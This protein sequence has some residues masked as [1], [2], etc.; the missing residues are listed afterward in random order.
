M[1]SYQILC[2]CFFLWSFNIW[3]VSWVIPSGSEEI[4][5][6]RAGLDL[7]ILKMSPLVSAFGEFFFVSFSINNFICESQPFLLKCEGSFTQPVWAFCICIKAA[8]WFYRWHTTNW[9]GDWNT[10][11]LPH[12]TCS[13]PISTS[14][15]TW[16]VQKGC[17]RLPIVSLRDGFRTWKV[18]IKWNPQ[19]SANNWLLHR[20][21][22]IR[23]AL[24]QWGRSRL[25]L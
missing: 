14:A 13:A 8:D 21:T 20:S 4:V 3:V 25:W 6:Q 2:F 23:S 15:P 1:W 7:L 12:V 24:Q 5:F 9:R 18:D 22:N 19:Q 17:L 10:Q 16:W 11:P